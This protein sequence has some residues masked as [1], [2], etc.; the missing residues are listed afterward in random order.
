MHQMKLPG[1]VFAIHPGTKEEAQEEEIFLK[2]RHVFALSYMKDKGWGD[3]TGQLS[4]KQ[5]MEIR[6]QPGWKEPEVPPES[7]I[8]NL[9]AL[10][11]V[12]K[13]AQDAAR[14]EYM[15]KKGW[16][17]DLGALTFRQAL[18]ISLQPEVK[19][20]PPFTREALKKIIRQMFS[21]AGLRTWNRAKAA[22]QEFLDKG[23]P[24]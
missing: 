17:D 9:L 6:E 14:L 15:E 7:L 5:I 20:A 18:H 1:G 22:L 16:G 12:L 10:G 23:C 19:N 13:E 2:A 8:K 21:D 11:I 24:R 4:I 3:D